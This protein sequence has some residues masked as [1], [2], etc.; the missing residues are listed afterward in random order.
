MKGHLKS[1]ATKKTFHVTK[2]SWNEKVQNKIYCIQIAALPEIMKTT[3]WERRQQT[4]LNEQRTL[5]ER[6]KTIGE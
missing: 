3:K 5:N 4:I 6:R 2:K 1:G